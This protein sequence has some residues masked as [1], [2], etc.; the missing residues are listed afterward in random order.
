MGSN[1][2]FDNYD[3]DPAVFLYHDNQL[4]ASA[5]VMTDLT[6][7]DG[8]YLLVQDGGWV[9]EITVEGTGVL[10]VQSG[11]EA[12]YITVDDGGRF[13]LR[14]D[15]TA[16]SVTL[17]SNGQMTSEGEILGIF[18]N[19]GSELLIQGIN[20]SVSGIRENG[21]HARFGSSLDSENDFYEV[22]FSTNTF[23]DVVLSSGMIACVHAPTTAVNTTISQ[24]GQLFLF[25][26]KASDTTILSGGQL[27]V[28]SGTHFGSLNIASGGTVSVDSTGT[29]DFTLTGRSASDDYLV[30]DLSR[31]SGTPAYTITVSADQAAGTYKLAQG[32]AGFAASVSISAG[33]TYYGVLTV[34]GDALNREGKNYALTQE[35]GNLALRIFRDE[36]SYSPTEP[37]HGDGNLSLGNITNSAKIFANE[38]ITGAGSYSAT[39]SVSVNAD[40]QAQFKAVFGG[41]EISVS[42]TATITGDSSAVVSGAGN[43]SGNFVFGGHY[44]AAGTA[45]ITGDTELTINAGT[46]KSFICGGNIAVTDTKMTLS[47]DS[48]LNIT[49][50]VFNGTVAGGSDSQGG[51]ITYRNSTITTNISGGTFNQR[52][53]GGNVASKQSYARQNAASATLIDIKGASS[54]INLN[55]DCSVNRIVFAS[56]IVGGG[57]TQSKITGSTNVSFTGLGSNLDFTGVLTGDSTGAGEQNNLVRGGRNLAFANF[58]GDFNA[59]YIVGFDAIAI[60]GAS[61][62]NFTSEL[63]LSGVK[64][65]SFELGSTITLAAGINNFRGDS[66][67]L[68]F[69][70]NALSSEWTILS[71]GISS[72]TGWDGSLTGGVTIGGE[73]AVWNR[74]AQSYLSDSY[75]LYCEQSGDTYQLK[76]A[77]LA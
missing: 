26:G 50:G 41:Y 37:I 65:W 72:I 66:L 67:N 17:N 5:A 1:N 23:S 40:E 27:E 59:E 73:S 11:G 10:E 71:G 60:S 51:T 19:P 47:G 35:S 56:D 70:G 63:D 25:G 49:G 8:D 57:Y 74:A 54:R 7:G 18:L 55:I 29:I 69:G 34:N 22:S 36:P 2:D 45:V 44:L 42:G 13:F 14:T 28:S 31:I 52:V 16:S 64:S 61:A 3:G 68:D 4:V 53:F 24:G 76:V 75:R 48:T 15:G 39:N 38:T 46:Y 58:V 12:D 20:S 33:K 32:A 9:E 6:L 21:G 30:N 43:I 77:T 62:V